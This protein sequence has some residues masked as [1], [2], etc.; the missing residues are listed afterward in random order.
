MIP[1]RRSHLSAMSAIPGRQPEES[2]QGVQCD[3][4]HAAGPGRVVSGGDLRVQ[5]AI[6]APGSPSRAGPQDEDP[7]RTLDGPCTGGGGALPNTSCQLAGRVPCR[8]WV[9]AGRAWLAVVHGWEEGKAGQGLGWT[10]VGWE[11]LVEYY[12][13]GQDGCDLV[14]YKLEF[15]RTHRQPQRW[16]VP[17][18]GS[19]V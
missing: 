16:R 3:A 15:F 10:G 12:T 19:G 7:A 14:S 18:R 8:R 5:G 2:D 13:S 11:V 17:R 4:A 6:S 1:S 9:S